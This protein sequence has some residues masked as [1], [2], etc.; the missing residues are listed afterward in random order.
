MNAL[1]GIASGY[2]LQNWFSA[3]DRSAAQVTDGSDLVD[4]LVGTTL[5]AEGVKASIAVVRSQDE[6]LGTLLDMRA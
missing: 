5:D 1:A 3:F 6:M 4:G 2:G